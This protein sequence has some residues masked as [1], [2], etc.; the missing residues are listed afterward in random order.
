MNEPIDYKLLLEKYMKMYVPDRRAVKISDKNRATIKVD[1]VNFTD[2]EWIE[3]K[4]IENKIN[5]RT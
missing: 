4:E 3:L 2:Q 5:G 1:G